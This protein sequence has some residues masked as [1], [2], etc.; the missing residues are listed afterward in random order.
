MISVISLFSFSIRCIPDKKLHPVFFVTFQ[1]QNSTLQGFGALVRPHLR[2]AQGSF[3]KGRFLNVTLKTSQRSRR[4][5]A[6]IFIVAMV[7]IMDFAPE[8]GTS[9]SKTFLPG[10][11]LQNVF[12]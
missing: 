9:D 7:I 5:L 11:R 3:V 1:V 10:W 6:F 8:T 12:Y 4:Q 2:N